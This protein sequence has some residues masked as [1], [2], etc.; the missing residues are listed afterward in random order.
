MAALPILGDGQNNLLRKITENTYQTAGSVSSFPIPPFDEV[1]ITYYGSTNN[2]YQ[3]FY[4]NGGSSVKTLTLTYV[5]GAVAD[6]DRLSN[7]S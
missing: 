5:G 1:D 2:I 6:N 7:I 4:K 3:V